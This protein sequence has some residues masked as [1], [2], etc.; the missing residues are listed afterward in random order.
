MSDMV[1]AIAVYDSPVWHTAGVAGSAI[2]YRGPFHE[3][4][5]HS[6]PD[7]SGTAAVYCVVRS[8]TLLDATDDVIGASCAEAALPLTEQTSAG[9]K[10]IDWGLTET[11][12]ASSGHIERALRAGRAP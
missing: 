3:F 4:H 1:K 2:S 10:R 9:N 5:D 6:G 8:E 7:A 12:D 11:A